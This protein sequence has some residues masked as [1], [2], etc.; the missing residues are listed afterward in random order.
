MLRR[1]DRRSVE[2]VGALGYQQVLTDMLM[3]TTEDKGIKEDIYISFF[4]GGGNNSRV[5]PFDKAVEEGGDGGL[6]VTG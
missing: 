4:F 1:K 2:V 3:D 6:E 5:S